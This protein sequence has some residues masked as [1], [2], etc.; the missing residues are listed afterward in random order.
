MTMARQQVAKLKERR[1][2][3]SLLKQEQVTRLQR[4][5]D[6]ASLIEGIR[7]AGLDG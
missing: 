3:W 7:L 6:M 1:P 5:E 4:D 2:D